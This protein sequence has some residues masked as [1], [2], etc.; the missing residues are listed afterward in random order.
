MTTF[1]TRARA[2]D[3]LGRQQ[4]A[5]LPTA[6]SELF[7]NSHDAYATHARADFFRVSNLLAVT[8]DGNGMDRDPSTVHRELARCADISKT[9][10]RFGSGRR[11][12]YGI[13]SN[14]LRSAR[15]HSTPQSRG[16]SLNSSQSC[17]SLIRAI[18]SA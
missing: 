5:S 11:A 13:A 3:I 6:L 7:K 9:V 18:R 1:K 10:W 15:A 8:D 12:G 16:K 4:I 2:V 17:R 14:V